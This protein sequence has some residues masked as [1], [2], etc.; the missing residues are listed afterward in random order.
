MGADIKVN[1]NV[2]VVKGVEKLSGTKIVAPDIRGGAAL[3]VAGLIAEGKTEVTGLKHIDRGYE[4]LAG[5]LSLLGAD[6]TRTKNISGETSEE[7]NIVE[8]KKINT[9]KIV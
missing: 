6:I 7:E 5:R 1:N 8:E 2:A 4:D 9:Q 3:V